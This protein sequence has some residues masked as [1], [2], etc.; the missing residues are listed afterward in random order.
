MCIGV[1]RPIHDDMHVEVREHFPGVSSTMWAPGVEFRCDGKSLLSLS[2]AQ[3]E[4]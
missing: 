2:L 3:A 1:D 4:H